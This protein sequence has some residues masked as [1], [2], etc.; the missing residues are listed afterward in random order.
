MLEVT[1]LNA[2]N[3][4]QFRSDSKIHAFLPLCHAAF[5][6]LWNN[7]GTDLCSEYSSPRN[8]RNQKGIW[9]LTR[10]ACLPSLSCY[11]NERK[12]RTSSCA[13]DWVCDRS[14]VGPR[15]VFHHLKQIWGAA[16][17]VR[18]MV[19]PSW[20]SCPKDAVSPQARGRKSPFLHMGCF[21]NSGAAPY[22]PLPDF[23]CLSCVSLEASA[24]YCNLVNR[25]TG[26][27]AAGVKA[28]SR[29]RWGLQALMV[30]CLAPLVQ[31]KMWASLGLHQ[32]A[33]L[34]APRRSFPPVC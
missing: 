28:S 16:V 20:C 25:E 32:Q 10:C 3:W 17:E 14:S 15:A 30:L 22:D 24:W 5:M 18:G 29:Q 21:L 1:H 7:T 27:T 9:P 12:M 34:W 2:W 26:N 11:C 8:C 23:L 33:V 6:G 13:G 31:R 19:G 4:S